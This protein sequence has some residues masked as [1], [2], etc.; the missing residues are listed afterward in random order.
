MA[1]RYRNLIYSSAEYT[2]L[3]G[4]FK[5]VELNAG[6]LVSS[7]YRLAY[8]ENMYKDYDANGADVIESIPGFRC[9]AHY[10]ES[11][12]G[13]YYQ[14]STGEGE[15]HL[16]VH[17]GNRL[18]RH[19]V[20][21]IDRKNC[22]GKEISTVRNA[23]SFGFEFGRFFYVMDGESILRIDEDGECEKVGEGAAPYVPTTYVSGESYESRN[24]LGDKFKEETYLADPTV[25][26]FATEGL[27]FTITD[28]YLKYCAVNGVKSDVAGA[29][30][31]PAYVNIAGTEYKVTAIADNA[32]KNNRKIT[33]VIIAHGVSEIGKNAF[34]GCSYLSLAALPPTMTKIGEYAFS[35]CTALK[36]FYLGA[37]VSEIGDGA[38]MMTYALGCTYY[39]LDESDLIKINGY[40]RLD[41]STVIYNTPYERIRI[42]LRTHDK[43]A[44]IE[45]VTADG[46]AMEYTTL[47][48]D[49]EAVGVILDFQSISE[50]TGMKIV[51]EGTLKPL[52]DSWCEDMT[53]LS[54]TSAAEAVT[55]C[56]VAEVFD[57]RIFFS[58]NP[59][60]PNTVFYTDRT[61]LG[62]DGA[63]SVGRYNY[64]NDGVGS[65]KVR[66]MLAVRDMLAVFKEGDDGSG[67][68]FYHKRE[69]TSLNA[70][71]TVYP[72]AYVHSGIC[73]SGCA[74]SFLDDPVFISSEGVM[75]LNSEN[76]NYQ[77]NVVC[78]SHNVNYA[79][80][81]SD[82]SHASMCE[83][84]G[85]LVVGIGDT[86]LLADSRALFSHP[87][88]S[89]EYEWFMLKGIGAYTGSH[90]LFR[91]ADSGNSST[92][93]HP[94]LAG[95]KVRYEDVMSDTDL[96]GVTFYYVTNQGYNYLVEP[97]E[98]RS[99]GV[100]HPATV[101]LSH[102]KRLFF[103]TGD[104]HLC[105]FN[106]DKRGVAP[107]SV[108]EKPDFDE[109]EYQ[110]L[111]G[112]RIHP[113]FY[114]FDS[115][116]TRYA[117]R[118]ALDDCGIPH[119]T[120]ST[121]KKSL[122]IKAKSHTPDAI[123]CEVITDNNEPVTVGS[124]PAA[125]V[126]FDSLD[127]TS[128]PWYVSRYSSVA[129]AEN[130]K[131]WIEK[132]IHLYSEK[133]ACPISISSI[134]YRY[135]IKGKIKNNV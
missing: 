14:R 111:M 62:N 120:K 68:I 50:A 101:Y 35:S 133:F 19:P 40:D 25:H 103:A 30:Y 22:I 121:V 87:A 85:Y 64:F 4:G 124:F 135:V 33:S 80:L 89:Y 96:D 36:N 74:F 115:H 129:L 92:L 49:G 38:F 77:R 31:I 61:T 107:D 93:G 26:T 131:R 113:D 60:F 116:A 69:S 104:G 2:H 46:E 106:N 134:S 90:T 112:D 75:A 86:V 27:K 28:A 119:L 39:A 99:G 47:Y 94:T 58:G 110:S 105:V 117:V 91:Y 83:W 84:L 67:S 70:L 56:T 1:N 52:E 109:A 42:A 78:R 10:G 16:I 108:R 53:P 59:S 32:F 123:T 82:L 11:V 88:G 8:S 65:Y 5:G 100:F 7:K 17:V 66:C 76:I 95:E 43:T 54:P 51:I 118:T 63:L 127:F 126:G 114:A 45:A 21:D 57:G 55:H 79:L 3:Y 130:E 122:V 24:L 29:I 15:D 13:I 18:M 72:V 48:E 125:S 6:S 97:S 41:T 71:D 20:S 37:G 81:K 12:H 132:Q 44:S 9:F 102:G 23:K 98:E 73:A 128:A 34:M